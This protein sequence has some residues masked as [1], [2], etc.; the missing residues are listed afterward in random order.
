MAGGRVF[1]G[2]GTVRA[3]VLRWEK[4]EESEEAGVE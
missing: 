4:S 1:Q 2:E 3:K